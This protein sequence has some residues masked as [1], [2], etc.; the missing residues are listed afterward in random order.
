[1]TDEA[2]ARFPA[3]FRIGETYV[4][5]R[6]LRL[7]DREALLAFA[8]SLAD[9]DL[10]FLRRNITQAKDVDAWLREVADGTT[11]TIVAEMDG[12]IAGYGGLHRNLLR[13]TAHV[14]EMRL[15]VAAEHRGIGIGGLLGR[16]VF[17]IALLEGVSKVVGQLTA[18]QVA[19][20]ATMESLGLRPE[21][22]MRGH[23]RDRNGVS[24]DLLLFSRDL[25][26]S[27]GQHALMGT[28]EVWEP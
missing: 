14:A 23:V 15:L 10:L 4:T 1:M 12:R 19:A 27:A 21:A 8:Q 11:T 7:S 9:E 13:W 20:I 17:R 6:F 3:Q 18:S 24:H 2:T 5:L 22:I 25:R 16:E 28:A 26:L